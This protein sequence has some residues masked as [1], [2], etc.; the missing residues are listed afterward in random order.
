MRPS[1]GIIVCLLIVG[2]CLCGCRPGER[3]R[4]VG[5]LKLG[6]LSRFSADETYL[7]E[8]S[9]LVRRDNAG[10]S[11]MS[12][13]CTYDLSRLER[14]QGPQGLIWISQYSESQYDNEGRVI[15]GP[16]RVDL[17]FFKTVLEANILGGPRDTLYVMDGI[18][19]PREWRLRIPEAAPAQ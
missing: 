12:T 17:P 3:K 18:E 13:M 6:P 16:A 7:P 1:R 14:K 2:L 5:Y 19:V 11:V 8:L 9:L 4:A 15:H 10:L